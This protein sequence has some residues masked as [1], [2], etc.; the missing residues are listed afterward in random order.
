MLA[1]PASGVFAGGTTVNSPGVGYKITM[2]GGDTVT[3]NMKNYK[4]MVV[5]L[6]SVP[7]S[8]IEL[9]GTTSEGN[10]IWKNIRSFDLPYH[11]EGNTLHTQYFWQ[12]ERECGGAGGCPKIRFKCTKNSLD[13]EVKS[14]IPK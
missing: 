4:A 12:R 7:G 14:L 8:T 1:I 6:V 9:H 3:F 2:Y 10:N 13:L 5:N 11:T